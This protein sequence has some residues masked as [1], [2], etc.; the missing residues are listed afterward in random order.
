MVNWTLD[1]AGEEE[2]RTWILGPLFQMTALMIHEQRAQLSQ[3]NAIGEICAQFIGGLP[4]VMRQA[5][6]ENVIRTV[7]AY[8]RLHP[9][10]AQSPW[11]PEVLGRLGEPAWQ[12][13]YVNAEHDGQVGVITLGRESY[14]HEVDAE[15]N[16]AIDWL[17]A[18][19]IDRVIVTGD[20]HL[21][22]QLVGADTTNFYPA[23]VDPA[24]GIDISRQWSLT[25]RRF[26]AEFGT[27]VAFINGK[28]CLG[29][30]L[31]LLVHC[32]FV[33]ALETCD[34]GMPEVTLPVVPG[35]EGCHWTFRKS[36]PEHWPRL[37]SLL[38]EGKSAK[39]KDTAGWLVDFAGPMPE[40]IQACWKMARGQG[41]TARR[42][43]ESGR[44]VDVTRDLRAPS[45]A[46]PVTE[47][48]RR[49]ILRTVE[50]SCGAPLAE[51]LEIQ[52]KLSADFMGSP[53]VRQGKVGEAFARFQS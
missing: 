40:A 23:L 43:F 25:A 32:H 8:H 53:E 45:A 37:L 52:A 42:A 29:G 27:S 46:S 38:L 3:M 19:K 2:L 31:E 41:G 1:A 6:A 47:T 12:Q 48:A 11:H 39:A 28:R 50:A 49:A 24:K 20:F 36:R 21:A 22:G 35:M 10:A 33:V 14:S 18:A 51:A 34:L 13:L 4:L 44:L 5:G 9:A 16:R 26:H 15:L 30:M 17:K 7:E